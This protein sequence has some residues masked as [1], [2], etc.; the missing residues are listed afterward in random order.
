MNESFDL[1]IIGGGFAGLICAHAA[2]GRGLSVAVIDRKP[3]PGAR[4]HTTGIVVKEAAEELDLPGELTRKI[5]GI[6]LYTPSLNRFDLDSPNYYFLATD[7][8]AVLRWL[9]ERAQQ[10]GATLYSGQGFSGARRDEGSIILDGPSIRTRYLVGADGPRS[11]VASYFQLGVNRRFLVGVEA[12]FQGVKGVDPDR[13]HCFVNSRLAPGY[14]AWAVPG[15]GVT[16]IGL[17]CRRGRKPRLSHLVGKLSTIFDFSDAHVAGRRSGLIPVN[18]SV[19]PISSER[20]LLIGDAAGLVSPLTAGGIH[21]AIQSGRHAAEAIAHY[22]Q[23]G[24]PNPG[25][26]MGAK[27]PRYLWKS[28]MRRVLD[29]DPPNWIYDR[30]LGLPPVRAFA[31]L[32]YFHR[33]GLA[34]HAAWREMFRRMN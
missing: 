13:L 11:A 18:G 14:I 26:V 6:R 25:F 15:A 3:E 9:A 16:Q 30:V 5:D 10:A 4:V 24:G 19:S 23:D 7:T 1:A 32:V 28:M 20:V 33:R 12:E 8:P 22:L 17:A 29:L 21:T 27:Y 34:S 31:R 2:A